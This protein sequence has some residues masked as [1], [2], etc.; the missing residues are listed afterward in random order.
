MRSS[1]LT[2]SNKPDLESDV[3]TNVNGYTPRLNINGGTIISTTTGPGIQNSRDGI[4]TMTAGTV[5]NT[6]GGYA[7]Y[8]KGTA[9]ITGGTRIPKNYGI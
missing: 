8:N 4:L 2:I 1:H 5:Q 7:V 6:G 9:N 3:Y